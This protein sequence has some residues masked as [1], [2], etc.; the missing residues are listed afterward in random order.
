LDQLANRCF[1][2]GTNA[3]TGVR[4]IRI[5]QIWISSIDMIFL[6]SDCVHV[7]LAGNRGCRRLSEPHAWF[8]APL[9]VVIPILHFFSHLP[10][11]LDHVLYPTLT[12]AG[13]VT[14]VYH[15]TGEGR[16]AGVVYCEMQG[17]EN[18][19]DSRA[20]LEYQHPF[21][22]VPAVADT[23]APCRMIRSLYPE[24]SGLRSETGGIMANLRAL[25]AQKIRDYHRAFYRPDNLCLI[26]VGQVRTFTHRYETKKSL[27]PFFTSHTTIGLLNHCACGAQVEISDVMAKLAPFEDRVQSKG[28]LPPMQRYPSDFRGIAAVG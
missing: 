11:Y 23:L 9:I 21:A 24:S 10:V 14:E 5:I 3:A 4:E 27:S 22:R 16:D 28:P 25:T 2:D 13:F 18:T 19:S 7:L 12:D 15:V 17:R 8:A 20:Y 1:A 26:I 6:C